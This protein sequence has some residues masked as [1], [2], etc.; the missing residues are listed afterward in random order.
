MRKM[1]GLLACIGLMALPVAA[2]LKGGDAPAFEIGGGYTYRS[3][4]IDNGIFGPPPSQ[5]ANMNGWNVTVDANIND[6]LGVVTDIDGTRT[7][8]PNSASAFPGTDALTTVMIGPQLY[9]VGHH[10]ITPF[11]HGE[12]GLAE[13]RNDF[14]TGSDCGSTDS[15]PCYVTYGSLAFDLGGG[16]DFRVT[17]HIA[18]RVA[19]FDFEQTRLFEP[20]TANGYGNQNHFK[21]KAGIIIR[22]GE[23]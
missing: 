15:G 20:S 23:R 3:F 17:N 2:Q 10:R 18:V 7:T 12:F 1:L 5:T 9:P 21:V 14:P 13:F 4:T 19:E 6:F 11:A 16:V 22:F 8:L